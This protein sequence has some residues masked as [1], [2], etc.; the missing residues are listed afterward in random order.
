MI[1]VPVREQQQGRAELLRRDV[2]G[3]GL[4]LLGEEGAAVDEGS[5]AR[6]VGYNVGVLLDGIDGET[7]YFE[8]GGIR[9]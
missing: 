7:L 3:N 5:F 2:V 8:H 9:V 4:L 1:K 6:G